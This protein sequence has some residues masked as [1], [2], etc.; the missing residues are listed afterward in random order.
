MAKKTPVKPA[1]KSSAKSSAPKKTA[2][3]KIPAKSAK[4]LAAKKPPAK[5]PAAKAA[6]AKAA[7]AK[8]GKPE[9]IRDIVL[10]VLEDRQADQIITLDLRGK[11]SMADYLIIASARAARQIGAIASLIRE[12]LAKLG[13]RQVR[14]EGVTQGDWALVDAGDV[15]L[16][17]FR[18]EVRKFYNIER[19][20]G[21]DA[22]E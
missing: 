6:K 11:S 2:K 13:I 9:Q 12:E 10:H 5:K 1:K 3:K 19:I 16:H 15:I 17:L 4:L 7:P 8:S 22:P 20:Y 14:S 18:P 21:A